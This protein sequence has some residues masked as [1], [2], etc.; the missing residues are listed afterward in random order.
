MAQLLRMPAVS[1]D[2]ESAVLLAWSVGENVQYSAED[3]LAEVETDKASVEIEA[4]SDGVILKTLVTAGSE[5]QVGAPIAL[6]GKRDERITDLNT[7][8]TELGVNAPT[9]S[10]SPE[11]RDV[12]AE[13]TAVA[14]PAAASAPSDHAEA[15]VGETLD[16]PG[17]ATAPG[18]SA[19][20]NGDSVNGSAGLGGKRIFVSPLARRMARDAGLTL[21][22]IEGTGP[23]NRIRR[24]DVEAAISKGTTT[25][26]SAAA[27]P[28]V[29]ALAAPAAAAA[30]VSPAPLASA[31]AKASGAGDTDEPHSK[32][33]R[34]IATRL[35]ESKQT[36]PHFYLTGS[37]RVDALMALRTQ[38][39]EDS[40]V[41]IS[42]NDLIIKA[43]A[44]AHTRVPAMN[45][46]WTDQALRRFYHVDISVAVASE[47]GL[48]TPTLRAVEQMSITAVSA[49]VKDFVRR[50]GV[51][52]LRQDELEGGAF[53]VSNLGMFGTE[54]FSA[55]INPPQSAILAVGAAT[56]EPVVVDGAL[57]VG[58]V[59][60]MTLSVDH[61]AVDGALAAEW[62]R[63][64][65]G[66]L[67]RPLQILT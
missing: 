59:M 6:L 36:V 49:A 57:A 17:A 12:L 42:V 1:A 48:V 5:V 46:I 65:L 34:L 32:L 40:P 41:K 29:P 19:A 47:R 22:R 31:A 11:R 14:E 4:E 45:A 24:A 50:A 43:V 23:N 37:A 39:N 33:R 66:I 8:L 18:V 13:T 26:S 20:A 53:S 61:R 54:N 64:F 27:A 58:M 35:T 3:T 56:P 51:G 16:E 63:T 44:R 21:E 10:T 30:P 9:P 62:L 55:I 28:V 67:E 52:K 38:L 60:R 2:A 7:L 15:T 25:P